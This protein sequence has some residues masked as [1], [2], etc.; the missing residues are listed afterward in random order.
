MPQPGLAASPDAAA[1]A[2]PTRPADGFRRLAIVTTA[3]TLVLIAIG[4]LVRATDSG[5]ACP[6]WPRCY[7]M[8]VPPADVNI[9]IEHTHRLV[10]GVVATLIWVLAAWALRRHRHRRDI[11]VP[12]LLAWA[13]VHVQALLGALVVWHLLRAELVTAHLGMAMIVVACL[14]AAAVAVNV[15]PG[16]GRWTPMAKAH[17]VVAA[18]AF[19]QILVGG[20][21]TGIGASLAFTDFPTMGGT[22][23]PE[24]STE[25]E[26]FH[27]LH[28][29]LAFVL[30][31]AAIWL[32]ARAARY[33]TAAMQTGT[34]TR[35]QRL[36]VKLPMW[37]ATLIVLQIGLGVA[38]LWTRASYLTV[39]PHLAVA[40]W[41]W[42]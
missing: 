9:W 28:R 36:V 37:A 31:G 23:L 3:L 35:A 32:A 39:T 26:A 33:R 1:P 2:R 13:L 15:P 10:A 25:R 41:I 4:G 7:G 22:M 38:N 16:E 5:L 40:S 24:I 6:D 14:I 20:H 29:A 17:A 27:V 11:V 42:A 34:W 19:A 30:L 12:V 18:L 21:V 8:W